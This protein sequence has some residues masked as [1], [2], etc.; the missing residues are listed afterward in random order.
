MAGVWLAGHTPL[1][2]APTL[3]LPSMH[4]T[5]VWAGASPRSVEQYVTAPIERVV[6]EVPGT[7]SVE[8]TSAREVAFLRVQ[9]AEGTDP[10]R[11]TTELNERLALL[12]RTLPERV[13]PRLDREVPA[14]LR[15]EQGFM[16]LQLIG[17]EPPEGLRQRAEEMLAPRLRR[18]PGL[19][20]VRVAGGTTREVRI[21]L[22]PDRLQAYGV[23]P[24][25]VRRHLAE[26]SAD[27]AF[28][29]LQGNG[30]QRLLL[31]PSAE[32]V[33]G[34]A[35]VVVAPGLPRAS[36]VRVRD[37]GMVMQGPAPVR[38]LS[39]VDGQAVVTL[40]LARAPGSGLL[41][42]AQAVHAEVTR[43]QALLPAGIRLEVADDR[44]EAVRA[45]VRSLTRQG[46]LGLV[47][48]GIVLW[49]LLG[50]LRVVAAL[51]YSV[52]VALAAALVALRPLGLTLN[53]VT[54]SGLALLF[55][56]LVDN[57]ILMMEA[58]L[59]AARN[60]TGLGSRRARVWQAV[61]V[62][63]LG[64]TLTTVIVIVP[65]VY[66]SGELR[67]LFV[68]FGILVGVALGA[69][70]LSAFLVIPALGRWMPA[71]RFS[72]HL[73][74]WL[75][76]VLQVPFAG[77]VRY[78]RWYL[79]GL[80]LLIGL[81][82][83]RVP[84]QIEVPEEGW[85]PVRR[86][87]VRHYNAVMGSDLVADLRPVVEAVLGGVTRP[88]LQHLTF[89]RYRFDD[90]GQVLV[91]VQLPPG[92]TLAQTESLITRFER[93]ALQQ[94]GVRRTLLQ[95]EETR[96]SLQ[97]LF[98]PEALR[99]GQAYRVREALIAE[100]V[101]LAGAEIG[102][103]GLLPEGYYAGTSGLATNYQVEAYGSNYDDLQAH[104]EAF[105]ARLRR[106]PRIAWV[107]PLVDVRASQ[108]H[109]ETLVLRWEAA[110]V[111]QTGITAHTLTSLLRPALATT[112]PAFYAALDGKRP[113][114]VRILYEGAEHLQQLDLANRP[115]PLPDGSAVRLQDHARVQVRP[116]PAAITRR[117][118]QYRQRIHIAYLGPWAIGQAFVQA[119]VASMPMP[120]GY[121]LEMT[122]PLFFDEGQ[123]MAFGWVMAAAL[124]AVLL[125][126]AMVM[127]SWRQ[128]LV[129]VL[130][131][132]GAVPGVALGFLWSGAPFAEGAFIGM[133]LLVGVGVN[134]SLLLVHTW[135]QLRK[136]HPRLPNPTALRLAVRQRL[137]PMWA[138]TLTSVA[139]MLPLLLFASHS[140][141]WLGLVVTSVGGLASGT[142][143]S[144]LCC[145][146][147]LARMR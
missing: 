32:T 89:G 127:A 129:V 78:P 54:L 38:S 25:A 56:L 90:K 24:E 8:S 94:A 14:A 130:S 95:G 69:S 73:P 53:L 125:I 84:S 43:L 26:V 77:A 109:T 13:Y 144:P 118:Q 40:V 136:T 104:V 39:R 100:A 117:N 103:S 101:G 28:G 97:V 93:T 52:A 67:A 134:N 119:Q 133:V 36:P 140:D 83:W 141:F 34:L 92:S 106:N 59:Q 5:A 138:T 66:L 122:N 33:A 105:A 79:A 128:A 132:F 42:V 135:Q 98:H 50:S 139:G 46:V 121:R 126:T 85:G 142:L 68:P 30:E 76:R 41:Q 72:A 107:N 146:I 4:I 131:L 123:K 48:V 64:G 27:A 29:Q 11:Y 145:L 55:G 49:M 17:H 3:E 65:L 23:S 31:R 87:L 16:T 75:R 115:L 91:G 99:S 19:A 60:M 1:E 18:I 51:L 81:P 111:A 82:V 12:Q 116:E 9:M 137:H 58:W 63:M 70:L 20:Q 37:V 45:S 86:D 120:P 102:V 110:A 2:W 22:Q 47:L 108:Q 35:E 44:S 57:A 74:R 96:A 113:L 21:V 7:A 143:F 147:G 124:G 62:P 71:V 112:Y 114:P 88:F 10:A 80:V 61:H 6:E 15:D